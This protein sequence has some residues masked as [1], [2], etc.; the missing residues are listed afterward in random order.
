[1]DLKDVL[2]L[3]QPLTD[4]GIRSVNFFNGRLL[5]G[6]DLSREQAARREADSRLG[7]AV[8]DGVA[9]GLEAMRDPKLD[10]PA[11]PVL[12]IRPGLAVNRLG[13]T[14][15]LAAD[16]SVALTRSFEAAGAE[17][18]FANCT[19][20]T[21]GTYVAGA[22]IYLLTIAPAQKGEGRAASNGLDPANVA[23]NTDAT[24]EAVQFR[25]INVNPLRYAGLDIASPQFRNRLAYRCFGIEARE[26]NAIDPWRV[27]APRYGLIDE[28]REVGL[29]DRDVPLALVYWTAGGIKFIDMWAARRRLLEPDALSGFSFQ[30]DPLKPEELS[31]FSFIA[32]RRR[33]VEAHA[34]CAQFQQHLGDVL[35][36]AAN[37]GT[38]IASQYFRYLPPFGIVPL[39][40][41][42][43]RG[44]LESSFFSGIVRR[45]PPG[46]NQLTPFIDARL[47]GAL[48]E[49][50][51][52]HAPTDLAQKEFIRV[53]RA[54]QNA[55][56]AADG[57]SVQPMVAF[58]SGLVPELAIAR[59]D[60][61]RFDYSDY[62]NC[63]GG[64]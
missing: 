57:E 49:L 34:M 5:S 38:V 4:G 12:R 29:D 14:L 30:R 32:R 53:Y 39:Q 8:G 63:C 22:G 35:A 18:V 2:Q 9:F 48:Q 1:M 6:K 55:R 21:G 20:L 45:P 17:C 46:S 54:W 43:L 27:D 31:S 25:L 50:A 11:A 15:R 7:L 64:S 51:L 52:A 19:P 37:P 13:Q 40:S 33:L 16:V 3:Q 28:L 36:A 26:Q 61:A 10:K 60:M 62:A 24:V 58:A 47:L 59:F 23:C 42:P 44:F 41:P 56:A